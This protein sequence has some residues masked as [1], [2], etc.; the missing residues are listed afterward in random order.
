MTWS[1]DE[2]DAGNGLAALQSIIE[3][4]P[5]LSTDVRCPILAGVFRGQVTSMMEGMGGIGNFL[6]L[7]AFRPG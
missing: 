2:E 6:K 5:D 1:V 7:S 4:N 3:N